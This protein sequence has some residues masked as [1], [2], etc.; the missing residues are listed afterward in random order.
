[1]KVK[2][3]KGKNTRVNYKV[4]MDSVSYSSMRQKDWFEDEEKEEGLQSFW[5]SKQKHIYDDIY[6]TM[7]KRV[8]I[9]RM[10]PRGG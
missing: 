1:M 5:C 7:S 6:Q 9:T 8:K 3:R 2:A 10:S 4:G